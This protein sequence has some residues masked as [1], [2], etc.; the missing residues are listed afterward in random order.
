MLKQSAN[1]IIRCRVGIIVAL[2]LNIV[3]YYLFTKATF[4]DVP[5]TLH[6]FANKNRQKHIGDNKDNKLQEVDFCSKP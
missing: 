5:F 2:R 6:S 4:S 3:V 1:A